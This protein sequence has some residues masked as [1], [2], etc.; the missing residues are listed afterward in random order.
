MI[1]LDIARVHFVEEIAYAN[2]S[3]EAACESVVLHTTGHDLLIRSRQD[4]TNENVRENHLLRVDIKAQL[5]QFI[6]VDAGKEFLETGG[7]VF[8]VL[9][10]K[11]DDEL[12]ILL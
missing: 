6:E 9:A 7:I 10:I 5:F 1:K 2:D 4:R 3:R 12:M 11:V 8:E